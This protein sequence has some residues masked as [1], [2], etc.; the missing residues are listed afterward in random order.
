M[1]LLGHSKCC[2]SKT[3]NFGFKDV[4]LIFSNSFK[5]GSNH[6]HL[7][8]IIN[9]GEN[10]ESSG[11]LVYMLDLSVLSAPYPVETLGE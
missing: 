9:D 10:S 7:F 4:V 11:V 6:G 1:S 8:G 2:Y 3:G 5:Q